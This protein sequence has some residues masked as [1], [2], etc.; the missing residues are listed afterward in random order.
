MSTDEK[1]LDQVGFSALERWRDASLGRAFLVILEDGPPV[2]TLH[3]QGLTVAGGSG[4]TVYD[5]ACVA[6][7][8]VGWSE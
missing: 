6:L 8:K 3:E 1:G 4:K 5:A 2:V 7:S